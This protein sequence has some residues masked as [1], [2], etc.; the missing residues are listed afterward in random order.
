MKVE[1]KSFG[2][3]EGQTVHNYTITTDTMSFSFI[4]YGAAL[5]SIQMPDNKG[6]L[7]DVVIG[8]NTIGDYLQNPNYFG[9]SIGRVGGRIAE[10][11]FDLNGKQYELEENLPPHH[12]HGGSN[13][14]SFK[15]FDTQVL[16]NPDGQEI[17]LK[18]TAQLQEHDDYYPGNMRVQITHTISADNKWTVHY[19]AITDEDTLFNPT[20]HTYFNLN[21][22]ASDVTDHFLMINSDQIAQ[23]DDDQIP[24]GNLIEVNEELDY[25]QNKKVSL[26]LDHPYMLSGEPEDKRIVLSHPD[27]GR[28][29]VIQT[30]APA[31]IAYTG[32]GL[33]YTSQDGTY[34]GEGAGI[35]L[36]TQSM[37]D[38]IHHHKLGDIRLMASETF[39]AT[40]IYDFSVI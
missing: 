37:P 15:V 25:R 19:Y 38:A 13:G 30:S 16:E 31:V 12:I 39:Q 20:N 26:G 32:G 35:A 14:L 36:E 7:T 4:D 29:I 27:S 18:M 22:G 8:F 33:D 34:Y 1:V 40:T 21:G 9:M 24:T 3:V 2:I 6:Q 28:Q 5:Q 17:A 11:K 23:T 10:A